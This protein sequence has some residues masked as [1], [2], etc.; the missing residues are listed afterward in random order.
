MSKE[1]FEAVLANVSINFGFIS[2]DGTE[3]TCEVNFVILLDFQGVAAFRH[4]ATRVAGQ[5]GKCW[6]RYVSVG[7]QG[8]EKVFCERR[9]FSTLNCQSLFNQINE[10]TCLSAKL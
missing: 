4:S 5:R 8:R 7:L 6:F 10:I 1:A 3:P 2:K 9:L